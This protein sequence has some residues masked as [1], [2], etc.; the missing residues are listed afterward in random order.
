MGEWAEHNGR[1]EE[2]QILRLP[3]GFPVSAK[4]MVNGTVYNDITCSEP[5]V[6]YI[7]T[8]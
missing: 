1:W 6:C 7:H 5:E 3:G 4:E 2:A 8:A